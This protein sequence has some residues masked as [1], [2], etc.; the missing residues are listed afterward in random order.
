MNRE[1]FADLVKKTEQLG[2]IVDW[3]YLFSKEG[4]TLDLSV[5]AKGMNNI[6]LIDLD[7]L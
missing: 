2:K 1:D 4:F 7:S 3:Y 5:M 6:E